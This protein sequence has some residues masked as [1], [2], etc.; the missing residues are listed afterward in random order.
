MRQ[1][2]HVFCLQKGGLVATYTF[3][4]CA[5]DTQVASLLANKHF[6]FNNMKVI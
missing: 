3:T 5:Y 6:C 4:V 1:Y 2:Y